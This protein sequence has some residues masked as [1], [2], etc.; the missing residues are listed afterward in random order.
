MWRI[1]LF[2]GLRAV[3]EG[4]EVTRFRTRKTGALLGYLCLHPERPHT[5]DELAE[6]LWPGCEPESGRGSLSTALWSLRR[7]LE[8]GDGATPVL[9]ASRNTVG[10]H[11]QALETDTG[12]LL[13][14]LRMADHAA[15]VQERASALGAALDLY[16]GE[17]LAG[18]QEDWLPSVRRAYEQR[19]RSALAALLQCLEKTGQ[20][21]LQL[22]YLSQ[23]AHL[24]DDEH[25]QR[26][27]A[28]LQGR[29]FSATLSERPAVT[30]RP[31]PSGT[32]TFLLAGA[33][34]DALTLDPTVEVHQYEGCVVSAD[35]AL[36]AA[37][38]SAEDA[39]ACAAAL[40][41]KSPGTARI[42]LDTGRAIPEAGS[43]YAPVLEHALRLLSATSPGQ[44]LCSERT[45]SL[46]RFGLDPRLALPELGA[47]RVPGA[48]QPERLFQLTRADAPDDVLHP[49]L[50]M[51]A[52]GGGVPH[53]PTRF[54]GREAEL[55]DLAARLT[56]DTDRLLT[57]LGP[58]GSGKT[59][60]AIEVGA[61]LT[62]AFKGAVW[63]V[64]LVDLQDPELVPSALLRTL[65]LEERHRADPFAQIA[66]SLGQRPALLVLDNAEH[67]LPDGGESIANLVSRCPSVRCLVTSRTRLG[68]AGE[69][70][71][72][73][74]PLPLPPADASM[75]EFAACAS[76]K[77]LV[78]RAQA[79]LPEFQATLGNAADLC[80]LCERLE[81]LPLALELAAAKLATMTPAQV[82]RQLEERLDLVA[83]LYDRRPARHRSLRAVMV[84]SIEQLPGDV[85][86]LLA[87]LAVFRDGWDLAAAEAVCDDPLAVDHLA[88]LQDVALVTVEAQPGW[89]RFQMLETLREYVWE[90]LSD[91]ARARLEQRHAEFYGDWVRVANLELAGADDV[92]WFGR[93]D[94]ELPNLRHALSWWSAF[95]ASQA[96]LFCRH[97]IYYFDVRGHWSEGRR[98]I[99]RALAALPDDDPVSAPELRRLRGWFSY[100]IGDLETARRLAA[101]EVDRARAAGDLSLL[102]RT[103][104]VLSFVE[105]AR[106]RLTEAAEL[107][108]EAIQARQEVGERVDH[109]QCALVE[110]LIQHGNLERAAELVDPLVAAG[111]GERSQRAHANVLAAQINLAIETGRHD[112]ARR[113]EAEAQE[114]FRAVGDRLSM[115]SEGLVLGRLAEAEGDL[116]EAERQYGRA[117][118]EMTELGSTRGIEQAYQHLGRLAA[119]RGDLLAARLHLAECLRLS[120]QLGDLPGTAQA[121]RVLADVEIDHD[122]AAAVRALAAAA[123]L[124]GDAAPSPD[125]T[126]LRTKLGHEAFESAWSAGWAEA[127]CWFPQPVGE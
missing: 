32:V 71:L 107:L 21:L 5:R 67:L 100:L 26:R 24:I 89:R 92:A 60:L 94:R 45:A 78:D 81:G 33:A 61:R 15:T 126:D 79:T 3:A 52:A 96:A 31:L 76:V 25:V 108:F 8:A 63:F 83:T 72:A 121:L 98:W 2:G 123:R 1:E 29:E 41:E 104:Y 74:P 13:Y 53:P 37:F 43:Y 124:A 57:L 28:E 35:G 84:G 56:S 36:I 65:Q 18:Y 48:A 58:G 116:D 102:A 47:Y 16:Q 105:K 85:R 99:E 7:Q 77:L 42:V 91:A 115:A 111:P 80:R 127:C 10:L 103:L 86:Q 6:L 117:L 114:L 44:T 97:L 12:L 109:F 49:P 20:R 40:Q 46:V 30:P 70:V 125:L 38:T 11:A 93:V 119:A 101:T 88:H 23:A 9:A 19:Y 39:L 68:I 87:R 69:A 90:Q 75:E 95:D 110:I 118:A 54:F 17:V 64:P 50:A 62:E 112:D 122:P 22:R 113:L 82:L 14:R 73:L 4:R 51:V 59:R 120:Q 34:N 66:S 106:G 27:L 55:A